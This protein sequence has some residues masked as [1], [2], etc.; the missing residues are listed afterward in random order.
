MTVYDK[1]LTSYEAML[2][3]FVDHYM[4]ALDRSAIHVWEGR[5][6]QDLMR[7]RRRCTRRKSEQR[8]R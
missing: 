6:M 3:I 2:A 8:R 7:T 1:P 5:D 4:L